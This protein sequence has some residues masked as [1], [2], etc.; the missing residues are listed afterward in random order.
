MEDFKRKISDKKDQQQCLHEGEECYYDLNDNLVAEKIE[1]VGW[2]KFFYKNSIGKI[3]RQLVN[4]RYFANLCALYQNSSLS[5]KTILPFIE[6]Y[7]MDVGEFERTPEEYESFNDFFTRKLKPKSRI[8]DTNS[9]IVASPADSKLLV[10]PNISQDTQFW[11]KTK[12]FSLEKFLQNKELAKQYQNG[13][14][15]IFRLAPYDYHRYHFPADCVASEPKIINGLF[16]S[17]NPIA[18]K[19]G[20]EFLTENERHLVTLKT[21]DFSDVVMVFVGA[22]MVGKITHTY[23]PEK[24]YK[25]GDEAGYFEFGGSTVALLFKPGIIKP[26]KKYVE[27][28]LQ[29]FETEVRMGQ[30]VT[31]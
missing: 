22:M 21:K 15:L 24:E 17:V 6:K 2:L 1:Y 30:A 25:K 29:G 12:K 18:G 14:A 23:T 3:F 5:K 10:I 4:R 9:S 19:S 20:I 16:E 7:K 31:E 28:S 27:N 8:I 26:C 11:I 13:T